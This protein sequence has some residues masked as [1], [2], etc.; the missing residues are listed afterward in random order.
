MS[1][2]DTS[3]TKVADIVGLFDSLRNEM[4]ASLMLDRGHI[5][6]N[7]V[8]GDASETAWRKF[9]RT[10]LPPRYG[11]DK[12]IVI[13]S[14]GELSNQIDIVV[15]DSMNAPFVFRHN[16]FVY[17]PVECVCAVFEV[18]Q[19]MDTYHIKY[20]KEK[21]ESVRAL[22]PESKRDDS[23]YQIIGGFLSLEY[24]S[25]IL[26]RDESV[27]K[28]QKIKDIDGA[29]RTTN[30][31]QQLDC[32]CCLQDFSFADWHGRSRALSSVDL[33]NPDHHH[34]GVKYAT[35]NTILVAF[36]F[37]LIKLLQEIEQ[38]SKGIENDVCFDIDQY[39]HKLNI[40]FDRGVDALF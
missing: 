9:L 14:E 36:L 8:K 20:T 37:R 4:L 5:Q 33:E 13:N 21:V 23:K 24:D 2:A 10:Y 30:K 17:I 19:S 34:M 3:K 35:G 32:G 38:V 11:V 29:I 27:V 6:H 22:V 16:D 40:D 26:H 1:T 25:P 12:A 28:K 15:Y 39:I 31:L 7:V 18:K